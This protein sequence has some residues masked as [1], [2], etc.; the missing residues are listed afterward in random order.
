MQLITN[1]LS[2]L[3]AYLPD[4][5]KQEVRE[6]L[7][8]SI[9]GEVEDLQEKLG[10]EI[11]EQEQEELL[12]KLG[13]PMRVASTYLPN[14]QLISKEYF[15]A[16]K[17]ALQIALTISLVI[18]LLITAPF[19]LSSGHIIGILFILAWKLLFIGLLV[20]S[21]VTIVF[22]FLQKHNFS[23]DEIYAWSP[24]N[25]IESSPKLSI[26]RIDIG[27]EMLFEILF[28]AW[29]NNIINFQESIA[30]SNSVSFS[31]EWASVFWSVNVI[32]V[33]GIGIN[34]IKLI[35]AGWNKKTL[36]G[37]ITLNLVSLAI[38]Y[39]ISQ[40]KSYVVYDDKGDLAEIWHRAFEYIDINIQVFLTI[41]AMFIIWDI[42]AN[43]SKLRKS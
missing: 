13:H 17:R 7:E 29:W 39:Q 9:Y 10:R 42:Y 32:F 2:S 14:Q 37:N 8:A 25:I 28:L 19:I 5:M 3:E 12:K 11:N 6:E 16:Y 30:G 24:K 38:L 27:F 26:K 22:Y 43:V 18:N 36:L 33:I 20:F 34:M 31:V 1:Y 23:L 4:E 21:V 41:I 15:P 40:F 35:M